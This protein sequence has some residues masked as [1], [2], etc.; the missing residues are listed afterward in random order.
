M[1]KKALEISRFATLNV[2]TMTGRSREIAEVLKRRRIEVCAVQETR[3]SGA[4]SRDI[5]DG[6]KLIY[7]GSPGTT[8]GVGIIV[9][10]KFRDIVAEVHRFNDRLMKIIIMT[11]QRLI[12]VFS[13]Y[14]PQTGCS[15]Q[16]KDDFWAMIDDKVAEVPPE[17]A[18]I[19]AGD[20]NG[21][22]GREKHGHSCHGG[23]GFGV[24]NTDGER[25]LDFADA[26]NLVI[27][28]TV[29][30]KQESHLKTFYSG[31]AAT[32]ID[33]V[34]VRRRDLKFVLDT[35][36]IP[37]ETVATQHR[38]LVCKIRIAP[39]RQKREERNGPKRIKWWQMKK[40]END[41]IERI[42]L[43]HITNVDETWRITTKVIT[44]AAQE[45]LGSTKPGRRKIDKMPWLWTEDVKD[46]VRLKKKLYHEFLKDKTPTNWDIYRKARSDAKRT[47]AATKAAHYDDLYQKLDTR[48]GE[49]DI[50]RLAKARHQQTEDI[51]M[52]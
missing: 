30:K 52:F 45:V 6:F 20:L 12:H 9:S 39:P 44:E 28:N 24:I 40:Q 51:E 41:L 15:D 43:P 29:F 49:R 21:H 42:S 36:V 14:A 23:R 34:L 1:E 4:K 22:V 47:V 31:N 13:A 26:H 38:P 18:I 50:Y 32:Q 25:I 8:N 48:D 7:N 11:A 35:K 16:V 2:G 33:F 10:E 5:G 3:W 27:T 46:K 37:Y 19:I 17:D